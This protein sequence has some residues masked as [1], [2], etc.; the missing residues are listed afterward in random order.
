MRPGDL[1]A[2]ISVA[3]LSIPLNTLSLILTQSN[4]AMLESSTDSM[5][6]VDVDT[7]LSA[8]PITCYIQPPFIQSQYRPV[9]LEDCYKPFSDMF[10]NPG[11]L[12]PITFNPKTSVYRRQN[13]NCI[14]S[15]I[16]G[17]TAIRTAFDEV[18]IGI[19]LAKIMRQCVT[20]A[21]EYLGGQ[22]QLLMNSGWIVSVR[23]AGPAE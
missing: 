23:A 7:S 5:T 19:S 8:T 15:M 21:T 13:G 9:V 12:T 2:K 1:L 16:A 4:P 6:T 10:L 11:L 22:Q 14:L 18:Q 20:S 3:A 17:P